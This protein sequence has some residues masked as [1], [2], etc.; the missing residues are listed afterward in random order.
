MMLA[1][2]GEEERVGERGV[3]QEVRHGE[4][5]DDVQAGRA[6]AQQ[7]VR[8]AQQAAQQAEQRDAAADDA[9]QR[10]EEAQLLEWVRVRVRVRARA[11]A[12][13]RWRTARP[14]D[15]VLELGGEG[16]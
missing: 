3:L 7:Q 13:C 14:V 11:R 2:H 8:V 9:E 16:G 6:D 10:T 1:G 4:G 15:M 5:H 12:R